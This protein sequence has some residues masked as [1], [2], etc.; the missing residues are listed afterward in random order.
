MIDALIA[1]KL[2]GQ[3]RQVMSKAGKPFATAKVKAAAGDGEAVFVNVIAFD[4]EAVSRLLALTDG[5]AVALAGTLTPKVYQD[6]SGNH[7][8]ALDLVAQQVLSAYQVS[9]KGK[10]ACDPIDEV[11]RDR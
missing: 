9:R 10:A 4:A 1:G 5:E 7:R 2:Y 6:K 8:P 11:V 3:P